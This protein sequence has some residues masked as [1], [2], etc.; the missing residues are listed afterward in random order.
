MNIRHFV[1][2]M[3]E[4]DAREIYFDFYVKRGDA[5]ENRIKELDSIEQIMVIGEHEKFASAIIAPDYLYIKDWCKAN[6][7]SSKN[8]TELLKNNR[9]IEVFNKEVQRFNNVVSDFEKILLRKLSY[10][11]SAF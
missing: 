7:I 4:Q 11:C 2:N 6:N 5:S 9:L 3:P 1:S 8:N 10:C